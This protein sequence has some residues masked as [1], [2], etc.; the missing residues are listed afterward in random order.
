[1][2]MQNTVCAEYKDKTEARFIPGSRSI[3]DEIPGLSAPTDSVSENTLILECGG[4]LAET[5]KDLFATGL[6]VIDE[7]KQCGVPMLH[8]SGA[9][10]CY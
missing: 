10:S 1:M 8:R 3:S 5:Q 4:W 7:V 2:G 9:T 6:S